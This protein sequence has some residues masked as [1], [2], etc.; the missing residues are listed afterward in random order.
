MLAAIP[1]DENISFWASLKQ[2][3]PLLFLLVADLISFTK[4]VKGI[5]AGFFMDAETYRLLMFGGIYVLS[6]WIIYLRRVDFYALMRGHWLYTFFI[7]YAFSSFLWSAN[8]GKT[9]ITCSHLLGQYLVAT[10]AL[11]MF[12][13]NEVTLLR[14]YCL[15]SYV[16]IPACLATVFFFPDR[17]IH[18]T[19]RWMGLANNPNSLGIG[20]MICVWANISYFFYTKK[21][22][23]RLWIALTIAGALVLLAGAGSVTSLGSSAFTII[24]VPLF[25][26]FANSRN[27]VTATI[28]IA[29]SSLIIFGAI[30]YFYAIQPELFNPDHVLGSVGRDT[31]LTGRNT[32]WT[33]AWQAI[34][35]K[36]WTG[37][38]FDT[39]ASL[40]TKYSINFNQFHNGYLDIM[41]RGGRIALFFIIAFAIITVV[42]I[43]RL[44]PA[45]KALAAS[46]GVLL[47]MILMHNYAESSFAQAPNPLWLLF[48]FAYIG[49]SPRIINW[50]ETGVL[51]KPK[52]NLGR[53]APPVIAPG[54]VIAQTAAPRRTGARARIKI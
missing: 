13:G 6:L 47:I 21:N 46:F 32:L 33:I 27:G 22:L 18:D 43:V 48:T 52:W 35:D 53:P 28:K 25:Y 38:S 1:K 14:V 54:A 2:G 51:E 42:R 39:L 15:F 4:P 31:N 41:V 40:P 26:W 36:P 44:A 20:A 37:W 34:A 17:N 49:I 45:N 16:F 23:M 10:A 11:L 30:A 24:G 9:L 3:F 5:G 50:Y 29:Y 12:R 19:G 8:P 7:I